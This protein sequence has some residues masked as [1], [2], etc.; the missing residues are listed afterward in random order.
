[1]EIIGSI[2]IIIIGAL[3]HFIFEWSGHR[4]WAGIFFAVN[5]STWEHIKLSIYPSFLW[6]VAEILF[7][8]W[9]RSLM[10]AQF[11]AMFTMMMLIPLLFYAYTA[12][13]G[14]N[15]LLSDIAVFCISIAAGMWV[16]SLVRPLEVSGAAYTLSLAG[17]AGIAACYFTFSYHPFHNFLFRDPISGGFGPKG[18]GCH[19]DFHGLHSKKSI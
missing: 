3:G 11:C 4:K 7:Y 12:V 5:E 1:M 14:R 13:I 17:L 16:F 19:S 15:Y 9:S 6:M 8:G 18:H 2:F 10:V